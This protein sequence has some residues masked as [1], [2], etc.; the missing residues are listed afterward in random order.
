VSS[1]AWLRGAALFALVV[2]AG[3]SSST[4]VSS[5]KDSG[6]SDDRPVTDAGR[7]DATTTDV[8]DARPRDSATTTDGAPHD[9]A[10][11]DGAPHDGASHD[12][13]PHDGAT[14][15]AAPANC[16]TGTAGEPTELRCTGL[17]TDWATKTL[18]AGVKQYDPGLHL[19]SDG[20]NKTRWIYLPPGT[21]ID[22]TDMNEWMFPNGT[23]IWKE[24]DVGG[25]RTETRLIWKKPNG[26]WVPTTYVWSAD[27]STTSELLL[28][29]LNADGNNY[30]IPSQSE[31]YDC[32]NGRYDFVMGFEAVALSTAQASGVTM[33]DLV[34]AGLLTAPPAKPITIPGDATTAAALGYL[35]MNCGNACHNRDNGAAGSSSLYMRLDV[36]TLGSVAA[37]DTYTT[38]VGLNA[39]FAVP[40]VTNPQVFAPCDPASSAAYYRMSLRDGVG[41]TPHGT[42]MPPEVTHQVDTAGLAAIAAWLNDFPQCP[43]AAP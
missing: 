37:T 25:K 11:H 14:T 38:A 2:C 34:D 23:K 3:C 36:E 1:F 29:K 4:D 35:H 20:A 30:E 33:K 8:S 16:E 32:H 17:Y 19:W 7:K 18:A 31:C 42:Q 40:G 15:D 39:Y 5:H 22:T 26:A 21:Q 13:A 41:G 12:G 9:G 43:P 28:G 24:F 6:N 10:P 27:E